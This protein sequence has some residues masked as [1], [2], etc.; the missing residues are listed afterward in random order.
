[1]NK[2]KDF[3]DFENDKLID[4]P[5]NIGY[6]EIECLHSAVE[7]EIIRIE[8]ENKTV[9]LKQYYDIL[10]DWHNLLIIICSNRIDLEN[11]PLSNEYMEILSKVM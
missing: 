10:K 11:I 2:V 8:E 9:K 1:M 5:N 6:Y 3:I 7:R 4:I